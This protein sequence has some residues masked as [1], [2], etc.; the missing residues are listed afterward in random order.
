MSP[1]CPGADRHYTM[2]YSDFYRKFR[3]DPY[4]AGWLMP[5]YED[6][7]QLVACGIR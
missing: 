3:S 7:M 2:T 5:M 1:V 4:F 6:I